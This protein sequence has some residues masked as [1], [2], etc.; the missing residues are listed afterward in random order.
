MN[1]EVVDFLAHV[2]PD[3]GWSAVVA[4]HPETGKCHGLGV[5][6]PTLAEVGPWL[7]QHADCNLYWSVNALPKRINKKPAKKDITHMHW[8][9]GDIDD[10][11]DATLAKLRAYRVP[12]TAIVFSGGGYQAFWRLTE[13]VYVNGNLAELEGANQRIIADLGGDPGTFNLDRVMRLP[14]TT[15]WPTATKRARGRTPAATR[16]IEFHPERQYS[17]A[18]FPAPSSPVPAPPTSPKPVDQSA[19]LLKAV[20]ADLRAGATDDE[21]RANHA[22]HPHLA[23]MPTPAERARA[24]DR[25]IVKARESLA[26]QTQQAQTLNRDHALVWV[27]NDLYVLWRNVWVGGMPRLSR[28]GALREYYRSQTTGK[29]NPVDAWLDSPD[30]AAY[31]G[32]V[33]EPGREAAADAFN[34]WRGFAVQPVP[35]DCSLFLAMVKDII[36][37]G[38]DDLYRYV[39][40]WAADAVQHPD[41]RPGVVL[42]LKGKQGTGKGTFAHGI[43]RLFGD[44]YAY[45]SRSRHVVGNFNAHLANK[46]LLFAD[47]AFFAGDK[48]SEGALKS[49]ITE[50]EIAVEMKGR[51][52]IKVRN[53]L[54]IIM[55]SNQDWVVPAAMD[56]RRFAVIEVSSAREQDAPYFAA[57]NAQLESGGRSALLHYLM[58]YDLAGFDLRSLPKT[59]ARLEQQLLSLDA[60][61]SWWLEMLMNG[62]HKALD[63][64]LSQ[65]GM[66]VFMEWRFGEPVC[67]EMLYRFY[68]YHCDDLKQNHRL[69]PTAF[70]IKVV[71]NLLP[72]VVKREV[73]ADEAKLYNIELRS[74]VY[75][76]PPLAEA[77]ATFEGL[78]KQRIVWPVDYSG[79]AL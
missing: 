56:D 76:L 35:G 15:N 11:S 34:L 33:F 60:V 79:G 77:R 13:P 26:Q 74:R 1:N 72:G 7:E 59:S 24:L 36:A 71:R 45:A 55:A 42:V 69:T 50:D 37:S 58:H 51:D 54:R 47:E 41:K 43:G 64:H 46:L 12:P 22:D 2:L 18:D 10:P 73:R 48:A 38:N 70:G 57:V 65:K 25:C 3:E 63:R 21:V 62:Q 31:S 78:V 49:M 5:S 28:S 16:L 17:L 39:L 27:G 6:K 32:I 67:T 75:E 23:K 4:I 66:P 53:H 40:A 20:R 68:I 8:V 19:E 29:V 14:G 61:T 9:H 30:R 44:H 52:V